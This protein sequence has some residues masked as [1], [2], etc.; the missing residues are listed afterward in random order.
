MS[1]A[2]TKDSS[3]INA[4]AAK[5][6]PPLTSLKDLGFQ[7]RHLATPIISDFKRKNTERCA[8]G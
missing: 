3:L 8:S 6:N 1:S 7:Y 5:Q 4:S 2:H